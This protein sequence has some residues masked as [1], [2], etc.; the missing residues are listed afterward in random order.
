MR[1]LMRSPLPYGRGS[2]GG[3][4]WMGRKSGDSLLCPR[5]ADERRAFTNTE[6]ALGQSRQSPLFRAFQG[7]NR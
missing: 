5:G 4:W 7:N 3:L 1:A 2:V 6:R